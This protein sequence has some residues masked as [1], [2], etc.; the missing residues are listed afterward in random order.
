MVGRAVTMNLPDRP[1]LS[2]TSTY[3]KQRNNNLQTVLSCKSINNNRLMNEILRT[4][5]K[6]INLRIHS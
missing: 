1:G 3:K 4:K 6:K 5:Y 2:V